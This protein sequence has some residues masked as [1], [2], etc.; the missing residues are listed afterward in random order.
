MAIEQGYGKIS[1]GPNQTGYLRRHI[2]Q[3]ETQFRN[4]QDQPAALG[5]SDFTITAFAKDRP[6]Q[7][8]KLIQIQLTAENTLYYLQS[9]TVSIPLENLDTFATYIIDSGD[10]LLTCQ[11]ET[12]WKS[13]KRLRLTENSPIKFTLTQKD[14]LTVVDDDGREQTL[15]TLKT[16]LK[17]S[18]RFQ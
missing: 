4:S 17:N 2:E 15:K 13:G 14:R 1:Y 18:G 11:Q 5:Q 12:Y 16:S 9:D 10:R 7:I 3:S 6:W 8:G